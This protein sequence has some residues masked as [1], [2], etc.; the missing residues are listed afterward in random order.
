MAAV[1]AE[2]VGEPAG[3]GGGVV[4]S[5]DRT[6]LNLITL[7]PHPCSPLNRAAR[8]SAITG[9][10]REVLAFFAKPVVHSGIY[11]CTM[12]QVRIHTQARRVAPPARVFRSPKH[13]AA[14]AL[15]IDALLDPDLFKALCDPTRVKL[16]ACLVKCARPCSVGE[17]G[18][19]CDVD[20]SVVSRHLAF[21][22]RAGIL[23]SI[24]KGRIVTYSVRS[25]DLC[26]SLRD[27]ADAIESCCPPG[28]CGNCS[29]GCGC[30]PV[31]DAQSTRTQ[32][33]RRAR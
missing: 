4:M 20:L 9:C 7:P 15:P 17:V 33:G 25:S 18:E 26:A 3:E 23:A 14:K 29:T 16:L 10:G 21:L 12:T 8:P 27:I 22:E 1:G 28:T 19:C 2:E 32:G 13:A 6:F 31:S 5:Q 24:K 30:L 11:T